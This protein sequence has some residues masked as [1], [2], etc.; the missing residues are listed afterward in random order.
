MKKDAVYN[1]HKTKDGG[2]YQSL[3]DHSVQ[4]SRL[5]GEFSAAFGFGEYGRLLGRYHDAGKYSEKF[6]RRLEGSVEKYEHSSAGMTLFYERAMKTKNID[7]ILLAHIVAGHHSGLPDTGARTDGGGEGTFYGKYS[8][9]ENIRDYGAYLS[10]LGELPEPPC[11]PEKFREGYSFHFLGRM[12]FS[13][14]CDADFLDTERFMSGGAVRRRS[15]DNIADLKKRFDMYMKRYEKPSGDINI[16]RKEILDASVRSAE[17]E[18]GLYRL[19][20]PTGG[21]KTLS[22]MAFALRQAEKYGAERII[23]VIPYTNII[24]QTVGKFAEIFGEENVLGHYSTADIQPDKDEMPSPAELAAENWDMP[25]IVTTN[26]QFFESLYSNRTSRC[27]KLHNI[28]NSVLIFDEAQMLPV[29]MLRPCVRAICELTANYGCTAVLCTA[30]Q[31]SLDELLGSMGVQAKEICPD[32]AALYDF[33]RRVKYKYIGEQSDEYMAEL[34]RAAPSALCVLNSRKG[35]REYYEALKG[36]GVYHLSTYMTPAHLGRALDTIKAKVGGGERCIVLSTSLIEAGVDMDFPFVFREE[37]GLDSIIQAAGRCNREGKREAGDSVVTIF[38]RGERC[39]YV[40]E[41]AAIT[42]RVIELH[43]DIGSPAAV[44]DYF[45]RLYFTNASALN[46]RLESVGKF[47]RLDRKGITDRLRDP[48]NLFIY[49]TISDE[50][51][52]IDSVQRQVLIPGEAGEEITSAI[53]SG[54]RDRYLMREASKHCVS[55]Y[56][57][58]YE[59]F[60]KSGVLTEFGDIAV[61]ERPKLYDENLG[62]TVPVTGDADSA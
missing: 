53:R 41:K 54:R 40:E 4:T 10:E 61:L 56:G 37:S 55:L 20:V 35:A 52:L 21:G 28:A 48:K 9:A 39:K 43:D 26:V 46:D 44:K 36:E 2:I 11:C 38:K 31:P 5:A 45:D 24:R 50:F 29:E 23:Y 58:E 34:I 15:G 1:A 3:Y 60:R 12:L 51:R 47:G 33:F 16:K 22:S 57:Y 30:T 6:Q 49:K 18:R 19:T 13:S 14:L 17:G 42:E 25:V 27:R 62:L 32:T 8:R 7:G 59:K